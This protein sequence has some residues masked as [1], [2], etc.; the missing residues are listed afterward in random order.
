M[1]INL[2]VKLSIIFCTSMLLGADKEKIVKKVVSLTKDQKKPT[3]EYILKTF[4]DK[5]LKIDNKYPRP[6]ALQDYSFFHA[7][8]YEYQIFD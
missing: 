4:E 3:T 8:H 6:N 5:R 1:K 2:I 7:I